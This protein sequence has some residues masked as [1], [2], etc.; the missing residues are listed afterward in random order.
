MRSSAPKPTS[1]DEYLARLP[2]DQAAALQKLRTQIRAAAPKAE[3]AISYG[4]PAF[5]QDGL[6]VGFGA[7]KQH[8][9]LYVMSKALIPRFEAELAGLSTGTGTIRFLPGTPLPAALVKKIVK[10]RIAENAEID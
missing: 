9:A 6:L 4:I 2:D 7:T 3:E 1:I 5:K 10:A 8:C